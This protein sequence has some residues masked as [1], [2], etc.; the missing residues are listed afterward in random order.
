MGR[1]VHDDTLNK[2][3]S[4]DSALLITVPQTSSTVVRNNSLIIMDS[5]D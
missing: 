1:L 3:Q 2:W 4:G 5:M